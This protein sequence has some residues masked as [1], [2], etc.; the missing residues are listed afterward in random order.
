MSA[1]GALATG[2]AAHAELPRQ[3]PA[4]CQGQPEIT[5]LQPLAITTAK[6]RTA[7][8]MVEMAMTPIQQEYGLMCRKALAGDRGMLFDFG[9]P[10]DDVGFWMRNTLIG[11][12]IVYIRPDGTIL[13]I[14]R[15]AAPLDER[16]IPAGGV[17]R[18]VLEIRAGRAA[19]LGLAPGDRVSQRIFGP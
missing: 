13:S 15:N 2:P 14:A 3:D 5:P 18:A 6:G 1:L 4:H 11:L 10:T 16:P 12:D 9:G 19:E 7:R 8:F 17:I